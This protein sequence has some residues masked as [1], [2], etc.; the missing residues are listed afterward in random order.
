MTYLIIH[1]ELCYVLCRGKGDSCHNIT[2]KTTILSAI[3]LIINLL[4]EHY[5]KNSKLV[6]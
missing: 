4:S 2:Y 6:L 1:E 5:I 3:L